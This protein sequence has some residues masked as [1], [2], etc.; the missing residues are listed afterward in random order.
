MVGINKKS[1]VSEM[2]VNGKL[3]KYKLGK[4]LGKGGNGLVFS[5]KVVFAE[6]ALP[7]NM[8]F[9]I[10]ILVVDSRGEKERKKREARFRRE[11]IC[12]RQIQDEVNGIIPIF[13]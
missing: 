12:I 7:K 11:I 9:V 3:G 10:K 4:R 5:V 2:E 8:C 1:P 6:E 13:E